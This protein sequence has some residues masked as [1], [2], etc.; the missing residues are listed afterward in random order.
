MGGIIA[1][2]IIDGLEGAK[3]IRGW[4][5]LLL[6]EGVIT[7]T[8]G[9]GFYFLL[10]DYPQNARLLNQEERKLAHV[11]VLCD[12]DLSVALNNR[13]L[14][15]WQA[16][17]A[18]V[19]D[20][21]TWLFLVIYVFDITSMSI[22]YFIPT[23]LKN[24]GYTSVTAQWMTVPIWTVG[25]ITMLV[26]SYTSDKT[27]DRRWHIVGLFCASAIACLVSLFVSNGVA[28]YIMMCLLIAGIYTALPLIL[29]WVSEWISFPAQKRSVAIAFV[30]SFGHLSLIYGSYLWPSSDEPRHSIGFGTLTAMCGA[31]A[32]LTAVAP[33]IFRLLPKQPATKAERHILAL[34]SR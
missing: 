18:V 20:F 25:A 8:C 5:W 19:A 22:S 27:Q 7:V 21:K 13:P 15:S 4:R 2:A 24:L 33:C 10:P 12:R 3:G 9:L 14:T 17:K 6:I 26:L 1:G 28:K 31:A 11:R 34:D 23:I 29:N 16:F 30:N 32:I